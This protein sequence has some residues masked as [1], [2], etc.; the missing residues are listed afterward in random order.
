MSKTEDTL[1]GI[2]HPE[3]QESFDNLVNGIACHY[4]RVGKGITASHPADKYT[5]EYVHDQL[6]ALIAKSQVEILER[7]ERDVIG[8]DLETKHVRVR[9]NTHGNCCQC[10]TCGEDHDDCIMHNPMD[11]D[12]L[13]AKQR[14]A[15]D[16]LKQELNN[17]V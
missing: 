8:D 16:N 4:E 14:S 10:Q 12:D 9:P 3:A 15:I 2:L 11:E 6:R 1:Y 5:L 17:G 7:V 13:R